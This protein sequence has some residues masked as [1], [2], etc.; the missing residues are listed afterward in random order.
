MDSG[1]SQAEDAIATIHY[2][3]FT[4]L[5]DK[6]LLLFFDQMIRSDR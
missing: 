1:V 2:S 4:V 6:T 5:S 3:C